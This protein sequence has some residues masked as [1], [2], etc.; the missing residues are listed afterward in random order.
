M[1][2]K[3]IGKMA[4]TVAGC[5]PTVK[6]EDF[7]LFCFCFVCSNSLLKV[8]REGQKLRWFTQFSSARKDCSVGYA[9]RVFD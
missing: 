1:L 5:Y 6:L 2:L 8:W 3:E 4:A 7:V 9:C